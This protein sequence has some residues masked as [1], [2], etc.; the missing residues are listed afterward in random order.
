MTPAEEAVWD[1]ICEHLNQDQDF[2]VTIL[3]A[4]AEY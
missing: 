2:V 3:D 4:M 1:W